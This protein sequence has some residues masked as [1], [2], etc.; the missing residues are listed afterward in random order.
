VTEKITDNAYFVS[1]SPTIAALETAA[2]DVMIAD[3]AWGTPHNRGSHKD[4]IDLRAKTIVLAQLLK[5]MSQYVQNVAQIIAGTNYPVMQTIMVSSGFVLKKQRSP[6]GMLQSVTDLRNL[7]TRRVN[8]NQV[9]LKW[10]MPLGVTSHTNVK[11]Y[12]IYR[13]MTPAF[14]DAKIIATIS[15]TTYIDTNTSN[16]TV[17]WYY[18]IAAVGAAGDGV[19]SGA[20]MV[21]VLGF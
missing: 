6:Q 4:L 12:K 13:G 5:A 3:T 7:R 19:L 14:Y 11:S 18:W 9:Q 21:Q 15:K 1:P 10:E 2:M 20:F 16:D 17:R 8:Y